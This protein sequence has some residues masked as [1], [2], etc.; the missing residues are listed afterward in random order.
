MAISVGYNLGQRTK[1][2]KNLGQGFFGF[3]FTK[4]SL[5]AIKEDK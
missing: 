1:N 5:T 3:S 2:Q 4:P